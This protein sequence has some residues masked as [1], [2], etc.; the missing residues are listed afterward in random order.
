MIS[1]KDVEH[2]AKLARIELSENEKEKYEK[3]LSEI[4]S[5]VEKLN[6]VD[7]K[8]ILPMTGG[9]ILKNVLRKD[10]QEDKDL[11][12]RQE[13]LVEAAPENEKGFIKVKS[14][15]G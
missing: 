12:N 9:T 6:E 1:K 11:E 2:I 13:K 5:F 3:D 7:T 15:F 14:V 10:E 8:N 4:L